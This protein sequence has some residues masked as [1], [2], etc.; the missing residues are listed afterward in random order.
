LLIA[1][2][3]QKIHLKDLATKGNNT[4]ILIGPEG[5]F[6]P[7]EIKLAIENGFSKL[8]RWE[9]RVCAPKQPE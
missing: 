7:E 5:D 8:F 6:S 2:E 4:L 3:I 1:T 9:N